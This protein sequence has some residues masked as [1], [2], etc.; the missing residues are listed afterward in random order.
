ME[1]VCSVERF[2]LSETFMAICDPKGKRPLWIVPELLPFIFGRVVDDHTWRSFLADY[3]VYCHYFW[4]FCS[5][6][7]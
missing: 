2:Q 1:L 6:I 3:L 5:L 7:L 4:V